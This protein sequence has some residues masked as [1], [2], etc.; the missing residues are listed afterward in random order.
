MSCD[1]SCCDRP[2]DRSMQN[3]NK[4][5]T[6]YCSLYCSLFVKN[7]LQPIPYSNSKHHKN[8]A[9]K[10]PTIS[11]QCENCGDGIT[12]AYEFSESNKAFCSKVCH[13]KARKLPGRRGF[14]RYQM[15]KLMR[16]GGRGWWSAADLAQV[17]D[18]KQSIHTLSARSVAQHL[19]RPEIKIM[20]EAPARKKGK[21]AQYRFKSEYSR[22]PLIA[23]I[24]GDFND[25]HR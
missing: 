15:V 17:L 23:L 2:I 5:Q 9:T 7:N 22:Y 11:A 24:R 1:N 14:V 8:H 3:L 21:S 19:R 13:Q 6:D 12:L 20:I 25:C 16:D 4:T 18:N 10:F